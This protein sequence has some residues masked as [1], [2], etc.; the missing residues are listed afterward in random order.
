MNEEKIS[1]ASGS[2]QE[3][4]PGE[5]QGSVSKKAKSEAQSA[6]HE[7]GKLK[8]AAKEQGHAAIEQVKAGAASAAQQ[9][10]EAGTSY[11]ATQKETLANKVDEYAEAAHAA[12]ERLQAEDGNML[13]EPAGRAA[14]QL[15]R[16]AGYLREADPTD[17]LDDLEGLAR[18]RPE[19]VFGGLFV[20]GLVA[21]RFL[22]ASRRKSRAQDSAE[23]RR[24]SRPRALPSPSESG[25][26]GYTAPY[27]P[28]TEMGQKSS[29]DQPVTSSTP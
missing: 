21:A 10:K 17:F 11:V 3:T 25:A 26:G 8:D 4:S 28:A 1:Q 23:P 24:A 27:A 19:V 18:R 22:K 2:S 16:L 29:T 9:A 5:S 12:A 20:A 14:Q 6:A 7:A 15:D 13:A